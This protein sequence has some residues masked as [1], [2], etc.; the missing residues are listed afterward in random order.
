MLAGNDC[1]ARV[2]TT[3]ACDIFDVNE[4]GEDADDVMTM[5]QYCTSLSKAVKNEG[6][7]QRASPDEE[8]FRLSCL[9]LKLK[10]NE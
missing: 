5:S 2:T 9:A 10:Y 7:K 4:D 8:F 1:Y 6:E 3:E